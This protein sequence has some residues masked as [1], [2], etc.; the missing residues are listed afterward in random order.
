[1]GPRSYDVINFESEPVKLAYSARIQQQQATTIIRAAGPCILRVD[2]G[3][4]IVSW[5]S[6]A[7]ATSRCGHIEDPRILV[8]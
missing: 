3:R 2:A 8:P 4:R 1:M 7:R 5:I 6:N